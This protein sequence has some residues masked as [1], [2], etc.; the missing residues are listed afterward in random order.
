MRLG[1]KS[2]L[3]GC[4]QFILHP[5]FTWRGWVRL[6]GHHYFRDAWLAFIMHDWGYWGMTSIDDD[7]D[8]H[9]IRSERVYLSIARWRY[10][11]LGILVGLDACK[12]IKYHSRFFARTTGLPPSRLCWADKVGTGLM[13]SWLWAILAHWSGEGYIY[14]DNLKYEINQQTRLP[15]TVMGLM[16]FHVR[17]KRWVNTF[18]PSQMGGHPIHKGGRKLV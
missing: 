12:E 9:T 15:R 17:Y 18:I 14:M 16:A 7:Q 3:F 8:D 5:Y 6:Y 4:H 13:P 11:V 1:T 2:L 10:L